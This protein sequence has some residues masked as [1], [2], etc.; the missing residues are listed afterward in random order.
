MSTMK[1]HKKSALQ[2]PLFVLGLALGLI[3]SLTGCAG[4][5][6]CGGWDWP[7]ESDEGIHHDPQPD[8]P[9][10]FAQ[11]LTD[12]DVILDDLQMEVISEDE[13]VLTYF[14]EDTDGQDRLVEVNFEVTDI[15]Q[16]AY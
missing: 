5:H 3:S 15:Y 13:V 6:G 9:A 4:S 12:A 10:T 11:S 16:V 7:W 2:T 14:V 8:L 1:Q